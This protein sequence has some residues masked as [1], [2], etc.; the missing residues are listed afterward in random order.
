L[1]HIPREFEAFID[2]IDLITILLPRER[3]WCINVIEI[4]IVRNEDSQKCSLHRVLQEEHEKFIKI[5]CRTQSPLQIGQLYTVIVN[6]SST[7]LQVGAVIRTSEFD[8]LYAYNQ[9]DL[10]AVYA[11][12]K[13]V[14]KVWAPSST[15][16]KLKIKFP[17]DHKWI[18]LEMTRRHKGI[19]CKELEGD[20]DCAHYV[21]HVYVNGILRE[22]VDPYAKSVTVNGEHGVVINLNRLKKHSVVRPKLEQ[23]TDAIIYETHI[24]DFTI[25]PNSG[26]S[27]KGKF[28]GFIEESIE[29]SGFQHI[30]NLGVTH[31]ELL[32]VNDFVG[33]DELC[34]HES[35]NWGYNPLHFFAPEGSYSTKP[36]DPYNRIHELQD[37]ILS[38]HEKG[39]RVIV[40]VVFNHVYRKEDSSFDKIVPGYYFR[41]DKYGMP[42]N[43]TGVGNDIASERLM[44]RKFILDCVIYW[45]EI[46]QVDGFRFDLM[47]I[48]DVETMNLI[49]EHAYKLNPSILL[50]GEGWELNTP[51]SPELKATTR[52]VHKM[53]NIAHFNDRFRD[54]IKGSTFNLYDRGYALGNNHRIEEVKQ[55]IV[56][57][58]SFDEDAKGLFLHPNTSVNYVESHDNHTFWDKIIQSNSYETHEVLRKRQRLATS[59]V[60]L[61]QGIPF[62]HCGQ[63]FYRTKFGVGNSY[64]SPDDVN[65]INW[66]QKRIYDSDVRYVKG[67]IEIRKSHKAFRFSRSEE[68]KEHLR[69]LTAPEGVIAFELRNVNQYGK[70]D[71]IYVIFNNSTH[72]QSVD[73]G[74]KFNLFVLADH[75]EASCNTLYKLKAKKIIIKPLSCNVFV[76]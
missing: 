2:E 53:T 18:L 62:I 69:F 42:S 29:N 54:V 19:W 63:E 50:L 27:H 32:P 72:E 51:L 1:E 70:W 60:I 30:L 28:K 25:H 36:N 31:V 17:N 3:E 58:I 5:Q 55:A 66:E 7:D 9:N 59:M 37:L 15:R 6:N 45:L 24:R 56:G 14:F 11:K 57:S 16:V 47:G 35:Y 23:L 8:E 26:V 73:F 34:P 49:R 64:R 33:V 68:V 76:R 13:T 52:N 48:L 10:G 22:A 67:L 43:G 12:D 40:D 4:E 20:W 39:L 74:T 21:F 71:N 65:Q 61:S 41:Y 46:Y 75:H 44:V 38:L